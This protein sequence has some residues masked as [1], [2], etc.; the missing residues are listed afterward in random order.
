MGSRGL[1]CAETLPGH[2]PDHLETARVGE[3]GILVLFIRLAFLRTGSL[4]ISSLSKPVRM[5]TGYD[6]LKLDI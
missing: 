2:L 3:S 6:L 4:A 5:N 1:R